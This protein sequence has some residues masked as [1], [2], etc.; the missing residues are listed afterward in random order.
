M[1]RPHKR[2]YGAK[3]SLQVAHP[4]SVGHLE[5]V[6]ILLP[7]GSF[8]TL[9]KTKSQSWEPGE[10][11]SVTLSGFATASSAESE[12]RRLVQAVLWTSVSLNVPIRLQYSSVEPVTVYDRTASRGA[13]MS[14]T[15]TTGWNTDIVAA[16]IRGGFDSLP[17]P[18]RDLLLSMEIFTG[19][20]LETSPRARFL[21]TVSALEPLAAAQDI[22]GDIDEFVDSCLDRLR[23]M[24]L[25]PVMRSSM[26]SRVGHLRRESIGQA[27]R[28]VVGA[29][30]PDDRD[31]LQVVQLA[32]SVRSEVVH[33][34]KPSDDDLELGE[35]ERQVGG[36]LRRIYAKRLGS[37]LRA[38]A[39]V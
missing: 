27:I 12:G 29:A 6:T 34:G 28:R 38:R 10:R 19:A 39:A 35:L 4:G 3:A 23:A 13:V 16:S 22:G 31:A 11:I 36:V 5:A 15:L 8:A 2:R 1:K 21:S 7:T 26:L 25:D 32:Y 20:G 14:A 17:E 24:S 18:D 37:E 9:E 33:G 30:L